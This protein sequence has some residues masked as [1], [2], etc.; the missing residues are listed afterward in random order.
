MFLPQRERQAMKNEGD[1]ILTVVWDGGPPSVA[2]TSLKMGS[3]LVSQSGYASVLY[4]GTGFAHCPPGTLLKGTLGR[5]P[6]GPCHL[7]SLPPIGGLGLPEG[8]HNHRHL[9]Q[10]LGVPCWF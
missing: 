5:T 6:C 4:P 1:H 10:S 9:L 3:L 2:I 7:S 8:L